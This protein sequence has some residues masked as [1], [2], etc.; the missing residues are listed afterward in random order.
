MRVF[1]ALLGLLMAAGVFAQDEQPQQIVKLSGFVRNDV[2]YD[3]RGTVSAREGH[4][5]LYPMPVKKDSLGKDINGASSFNMLSI[6]SRLTVSIT[7]PDAFGA[8]TS[9]VLEG[10]FYGQ[11]DSD[12]NGFRLRHAYGQMKWENTSFLFGQAWHPMFVTGCFPGTVAFNTGV[13][14]QPFSRNPQL[15]L[16]QNIG[17]LSL[18]VAALSQRDF[19]GMGPDSQGKSFASSMPLRNSAVPDGQFQVSYFNR[20]A[21]AGRSLLL[22]AGTGAKLIKPLLETENGYAASETLFGYSVQAFGAYR[23]GKIN[24][25][26]QAVYGQNLAD[27]TMIGGYAA[28]QYADTLKGE[29]K[30][31]NFNT[32]AGWLD[33]HYNTGKVEIGLFSG[34][35]KSFGTCHNSKELGK[36]Y[37]RSPNIDYVYRLAPR[38][39]LS[40]GKMKLSFEPDY[41]VAA[42]SSKQDEKMRAVSSDEVAGLRLLFAAAYSF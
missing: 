12:I 32:A 22:G 8:K 2:S 6:T 5:L 25:K 15:R 27:L 30:Y 4:F 35:T 31:S 39:V 9:G 29:Y 34:Y 13:P 28:F 37:A 19:T 42:Y 7:G 40:S 1:F 18:M 21:D 17:K 41:T 10:A 14:F 3:N 26:L 11:S 16:T 23:A 20:D 38:C 24:I 36:F 33:V